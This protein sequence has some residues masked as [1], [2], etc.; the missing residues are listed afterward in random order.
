MEEYGTC[1][2][3]NEYCNPLSQSCGRCSR[4]ITGFELGWNPL[5]RNLEYLYP[6]IFNPIDTN[7]IKPISAIIPTVQ[8]IPAIVLLSKK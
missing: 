2:F 4:N 6:Q 3:C 8:P 1:C 5:N 7:P